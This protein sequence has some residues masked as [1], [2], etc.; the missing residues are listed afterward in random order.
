MSL[1]TI[2]QNAASEI[3]IDPPSYAINNTD[4]TAK[5]LLA[6]CRRSVRE[7]GK[8]GWP[9]LAKEHKFTTEYVASQ[10]CDVS[11]GSADVVQVMN[12]AGVEIGWI[13][14]ATGFPYGSR[15]V[16]IGVNQVTLDGVASVSMVGASIVFSKEAYD[17]P[18]DY[19][20]LVD[21][22]SWDRSR[23]WQML[24]PVEAQE[25]QVMRSGISPVGPRLRYRL[26]QGKLFIDPPTAEGIVIAFEYVSNGWIESADG[27]AQS[28]WLADTDVSVI[29]EDLIELDL[30][31][32]FKRQKGLDYAED[33]RTA[34]QAI[35]RDRGRLVSGRVLNLGSRVNQSALLGS[36]NIPDTGFGQS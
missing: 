18:A 9:Q 29:D 32:R 31:W 22:T 20:G 19:L 1:L 3:G 13:G 30:I 35:S 34:Q 33:N 25:W 10:T 7:I 6:L 28:E 14:A 36:K 26:W 27:V 5:Q 12:T 24:G 8:I 16:A 23:R 17:L 11:Q 21:Q 4:M 15:V 2:L